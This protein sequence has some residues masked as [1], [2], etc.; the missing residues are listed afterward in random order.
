MGAR[1]QQP[2]PGAGGNCLSLP[3]TLTQAAR[4][5]VQHPPHPASRLALT[6]CASGRRIGINI[7]GVRTA[8]GGMVPG[9]VAAG[10]E[11]TDQILGSPPCH[12]TRRSPTSSTRPSCA[13]ASSG[14]IRSSSRRSALVTTKATAGEASTITPR[15]PSPPTDSW[16]PS[17]VRFPPQTDP[18]RRS[19]G[20][21]GYPKITDPAE[22]PPRPERHVLNSIATIR[23]SLASVLARRCPL[24]GPPAFQQPV[25]CHAE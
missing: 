20:R 1:Q 15:S 21:L 4:H 2:Q 18:R 10:Q 19:S 14:T 5:A 13:G 22:P 7:T 8:T 16:S 3:R 24:P 12:A 11:Q 6:P 17:G 23:I 9:R 25:H